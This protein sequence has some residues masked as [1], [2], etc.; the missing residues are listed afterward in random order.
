M[1]FLCPPTPTT[2]NP[3]TGLTAHPEVLTLS[4]KQLTNYGTSHAE[5][6]AFW[7]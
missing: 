3:Q 1:A 7:L 2:P 6:E 5:T 4:G